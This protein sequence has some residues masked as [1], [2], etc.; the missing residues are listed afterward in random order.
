MPV[1][2]TVGRGSGLLHAEYSAF[3]VSPT[4]KTLKNENTTCGVTIALITCYI[5]E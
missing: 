1:V 5:V 3:L 4:D 2:T